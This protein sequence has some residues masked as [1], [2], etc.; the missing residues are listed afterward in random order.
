MS[1]K[2]RVRNSAFTLIELLIVVGILALIAVIAIPGYYRAR[3]RS[4]ATQVRNDLRLIEQ[5]VEQYAVETGKRAGD[6]VS[7]PDWT[8]YIMK[9]TRLYLSGEDILGNDY[10]SQTVDE[11]PFVPIETYF[12]LGLV[13]DDDFWDPY[14]P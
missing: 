7:V 2:I 3:Q 6:P 5:A 13:A 14:N 1:V 4:Q 8:N 12:E 10:G 9:D 11:L